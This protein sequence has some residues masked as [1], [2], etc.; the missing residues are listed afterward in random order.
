MTYNSSE[1]GKLVLDALG[2]EQNVTEIAI[3]VRPGEPLEVAMT[4]VSDTAVLR[5]AARALRRLTERI[6]LL[7]DFESLEVDI[8]RSQDKGTP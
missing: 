4:L 2:I 7:Q 1:F 8:D 5:D 6:T 3:Y